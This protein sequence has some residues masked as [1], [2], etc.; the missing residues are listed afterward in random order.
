MF[1]KKRP[2]LHTTPT[3]PPSAADIDMLERAN[4][5]RLGRK[6]T[7]T[8]VSPEVAAAVRSRDREASKPWLSYFENVT[9][10]K[11][12]HLAAE[13][14]D[15]ERQRLRR[16][17]SMEETQNRV[18]K[19]LLWWRVIR[20]ILVTLAALL[21]WGYSLTHRDEIMTVCGVVGAC[22]G[23]VGV[24]VFVAYRLGRSK[25]GS[26]ALNEAEAAGDD[27]PPRPADAESQSG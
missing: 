2:P 7:H 22:V 24:V 20:S 16:L 27:P 5:N 23:V 19:S 12:S 6:S 18:K 26:D 3:S 25:S 21:A 4:E 8:R 10:I 15:L 14:V 13:R 11:S 17:N 1:G 9:E